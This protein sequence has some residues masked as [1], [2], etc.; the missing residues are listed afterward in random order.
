VGPM[1]GGKAARFMRENVPGVR[2][3]DWVIKRLDDAPKGKKKA[4]GKKICIEL[5]QQ[6]QEIEGVHGVHIMAYKLED[7]VPDIVK[8]A[9][10]FP[11]PAMI[12]TVPE[13]P[14]AA[15]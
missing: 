5:V 1:R 7:M 10:L 14:I 6:M 13:A 11:R 4:E 2:I 15:D 3:P 9:G 8:A 12:T